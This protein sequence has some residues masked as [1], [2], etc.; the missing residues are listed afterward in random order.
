MPTLFDVCDSETNVMSENGS[1]GH[2][3]FTEARST[4]SS[5]QGFT[6]KC[7]YLTGRPTLRDFLHYVKSHSANP[8][9]E[10]LLTDQWRSAREIVLTLEKKEA[11][12]ADNPNIVRIE[13]KSEYEEL[14][15][16]FVKD[17]LV[18]HGFNT[19]PT[20]IAFV[21]LDSMVVYQK[22]ID[23]S[24]VE[25]LE[26]KLGESPS[27]EKVFLTCFPLEHPVPPVTW[28]RVHGGS[29]VF[30][31]P[32]NDIRFLGA[33]QLQPGNIK[34]IPPPGNMV[35]V[36]GIAVG[37][38]SNFLNAIQVE[39]RLILNNGSHRAY[40]LRKLGIARVPCIVQHVHSRDE[41]DAVAD[42]E[43]MRDPEYL[44]HNPRPSMLR[45]YFNP[46][47]YKV[48]QVKR[49]LYQVT[50]KFDVEQNYMPAL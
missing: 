35:G 37:F 4:R 31:S 18:Q 13:L 38:G 16:N 19:V 14:L 36:V 20:E 11:G 46:E 12:L 44:L 25:Q 45:D 17:P 33:M 48:M 10:G 47:L 29:Y 22:H 39:N 15:T 32:S 30:V 49:R 24:Y 7:L 50:V 1:R 43:V 23:L 41:L 34:D 6:D 26:R 21:E 2:S 8:E 9:D 3:P 28:S 42:S 40:A 27:W 5:P